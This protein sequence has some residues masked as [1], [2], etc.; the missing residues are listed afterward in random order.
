MEIIEE[1]LKHKEELI[2]KF[3]NLLE[4]KETSAKI[5]LDKLKF[6]IGDVD[7]R[8]DGEIEFTLIPPKKKEKEKKS[9]H[10]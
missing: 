8:I 1:I 9:K 5:N 6:K 4:G 7:I 3:L 10:V 2:L